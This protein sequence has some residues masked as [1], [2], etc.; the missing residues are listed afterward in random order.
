LR[1]TNGSG[2]GLSPAVATALPAF[3]AAIAAEIGRLAAG[4]EDAAGAKD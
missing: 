1:A 3:T 4:G 2:E